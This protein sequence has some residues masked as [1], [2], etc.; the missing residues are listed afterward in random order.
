MNLKPG[1]LV[2]RRH[3]RL[4]TLGTIVRLDG[5]DADNASRAWVKWS[6]STTLPNPSREFVDDLEVV[7]DRAAES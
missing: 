5:K 7:V 2:I 3:R 6:H 1:D 4:K